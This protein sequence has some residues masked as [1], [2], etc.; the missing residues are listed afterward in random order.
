MPREFVRL[1]YHAAEGLAGY[2]FFPA[3]AENPRRRFAIA[4]LGR[5]CYG[6]ATRDCLED[7]GPMDGDSKTR[8]IW[9]L[10]DPEDPWVGL[11]RAALAPD[12][13]RRAVRPDRRRRPRPSVRSRQSARAVD[14][15]PV[16]P[17]P[18]RRGEAR[19]NG[20]PSRPNT[21]FPIILCYSPYVRYAEL[22]RAAARVELAIPEA[23]AV[24]TF[25]V[26]S[27]DCW[28]RAARKTRPFDRRDAGLT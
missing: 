6:K 26:T 28:P 9:L 21:K 18:G 15:A 23:T 1:P 3:V 16:A 27:L 7:R 25:P 20:S 10:G 17:D 11:L 22:E 19:R 2:N 5:F 24:E 4:E 8:S 12:R 13:G 14:L